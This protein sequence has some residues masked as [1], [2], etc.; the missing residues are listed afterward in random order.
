[1][2][3][4]YELEG[5]SCGSCVNNIKEALEQLP[6]VTGAEVQLNPQR[7]VITMSNPVSVDQLQAQLNKAGHYTIREVDSKLSTA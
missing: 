4:K 7:I 1:M 3:K 5:M 2:K 6:D